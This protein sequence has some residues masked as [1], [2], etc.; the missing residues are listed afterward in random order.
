MVGSR[1]TTGWIRI[2]PCTNARLLHTLVIS[3]TSAG[4]GSF[5]LD[6][7]RGSSIPECGCFS[8]HLNDSPREHVFFHS[9]SLKARPAAD[10]GRKPF[11][12]IASHAISASPVSYVSQTRSEGPVRLPRA[13]AEDTWCLLATPS[14]DDPEKTNWSL[15]ESLGQY[16]TRWG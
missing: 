7:S 8:G 16:D 15:V 11:F 12:A 5:I 14:S 3:C 6:S 2:L 13:T 9:A 1:P 10:N 4:K